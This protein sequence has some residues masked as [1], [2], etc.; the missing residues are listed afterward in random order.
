MTCRAVNQVALTYYLPRFGC[1]PTD[2]IYL[3]SYSAVELATNMIKIIL[4]RSLCTYSTFLL[5][6]SCFLEVTTT[7][8]Y[9]RTKR[10]TAVSSF[11]LFRVQT[12]CIYRHICR[13]PILQIILPFTKWAQGWRLKSLTTVCVSY[14]FQEWSICTSSP[15]HNRQSKCTRIPLMQYCSVTVQNARVLFFFLG[16]DLALSL[17]WLCFPACLV[18]FGYFLLL[19]SFRLCTL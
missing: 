5:P 16:S 17:S 18:H 13:P 14:W 2:L 19:S 7:A 10:P 15:T 4:T 9:Y 3:T 1:A 12:T 8:Y 11:L 6:T